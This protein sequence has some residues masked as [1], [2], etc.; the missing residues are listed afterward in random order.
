MNARSLKSDALVTQYVHVVNEAV[1]Q[2]DG[3]L[4]I[5]QT[6]QLADG[7]EAARAAAAAE[8]Q[9]RKQQVARPKPAA[10]KAEAA[11]PAPAPAP[12]RA[13]GKGLL[14]QLG[15]GVVAQAPRMAADRGL[16]TALW[17]A[18]ALR[19]IEDNNWAVAGSCLSVVDAL[20]RVP[21]GVLVAV[22]AE[23]GGASLLA[24]VDVSKSSV[25]AVI[26]DG[27]SYL[28]GLPGA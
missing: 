8:E 5:D 15:S 13:G 25:L 23:A 17:K 11:R 2:Y 1:G 6:I 9:A 7:L 12:A 16:L 19:H 20:G 22:P 10:P 21:A 27:R 4:P 18:H 3:V 14:A 28:A 24:W 26:P